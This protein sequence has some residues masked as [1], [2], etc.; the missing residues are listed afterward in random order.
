MKARWSRLVALAAP[1]PEEQRLAGFISGLLYAIGGLTLASFLI[2]PGLPMVRQGPLI[3]VAALAVAWGVCS[4]WLID[5]RRVPRLVVHVSTLAALPLVAV[6]VWTSGGATSPAWIY[7]LFIDVFAAYFFRRPIALAYLLACMVVHALPLVYDGR[8][9]NDQFI[10]QM[11]ISDGAYIGLSIAIIS[12]RQL[13]WHLRKRSEL[14][15]A[16]QGSL[17]RVATAVVEGEPAERIYELVA[18]ELARLIGAGAA[19]IMR[20]DGEG[21]AVV[22]GSWAEREGGRYEPGTVVPIV[23]AG[24]VDRAVSSNEPV[25]I[26]GHAAESPV[27]RLG[28]DSSIVAPIR[29]GGETWGVLAV[30]AGAPKRLTRLD[31]QHLMEFGDLLSTAIVSIEDRAKLAAQAATDPLT[32]LA[33]HRTLQQRLSAEVARAIRHDT[34]LSVA[35]IDVDHFKQIND[36]GGHDAGDAMLLRVARCLEKLARTEDTLGRVGGDEFAWVLPETSREQALVAVERARRVIQGA[37]PSPYRLTVSAGICDTTST[38]DPAE[39]IRF[40]DGALYWSKA[41]GRDQCWIYDPSVVAELS[42]QERAE[43]LERSQ[44]LLGLRALARAI[45]AKDPQTREHS[46]RVAELVRKLARAAGWAPDRALLLAEAALVHDV[47]K[48]GVPD[49]VLRKT[50]P[51]T[52]LEL[53]Q[54]TEHAELSARIVE[55]VLAPE[56]VDWIRTHH[57][58]P[59]GEGYP[60]G[61]TAEDIPEGAALLALADAFDVMTISRPYSRPKTTDEAIQECCELS[62]VQFMP[63]AVAALLQLHQEGEFVGGGGETVGVGAGEPL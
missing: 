38:L 27:G 61:L 51:L 6:A 53:A 55:G 52:D 63:V 22:M 31:E 50:E 32:G 13:M 5:W 16:E 58:R 7:L 24:D 23:P 34:L 43:R 56:Q 30:T 44:A 25:R 2:L 59:N 35:V 9:T 49:T 18:A 45:D 14:L 29:V 37:A 20:L 57:E 3:A 28:Y 21:R 4:L 1:D 42:A 8:A 48:I 33:N 15:A 36:S 62:G 19:G 54:I 46:E 41:R 17:R 47:G 26:V 11:I 60:D 40:A 39:L 10:A 12:G